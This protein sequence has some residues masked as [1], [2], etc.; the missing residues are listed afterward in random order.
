[1]KWRGVCYSEAAALTSLRDQAIA[2]VQSWQV[3]DDDTL[4]DLQVILCELLC[5]AAEHGNQWGAATE[6]RLQI[7]FLVHRRLI[8]IL[9]RDQGSQ[10]IAG[11]VEG[12][13][14][15]ERGRGL[16]LVQALSDQCRLGRGMVWIRKGA[17][18]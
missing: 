12:G 18:V 5:N 8:L 2:A 16:Q 15:D 13:S 1:M 6:V 11:P 14:D 17:T 3:V 9:V 4:F 10:L 7:R